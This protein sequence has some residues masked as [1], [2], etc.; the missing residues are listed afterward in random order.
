MTNLPLNYSRVRLPRYVSSLLSIIPLGF[1]LHP[2]NAFRSPGI[3]T[4]PPFYKPQ[5]LAVSPQTF[6]PFHHRVPTKHL[7]VAPNDNF[8]NQ[9]QKPLQIPSHLVPEGEAFGIFHMLDA[10]YVQDRASLLLLSVI[11][12]EP[13]TD[14]LEG[15]CST[16]ELYNKSPRRA[17][18]IAPMAFDRRN[19]IRLMSFTLRVTRL[20]EG[21]QC[22]KAQPPHSTDYGR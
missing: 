14:R 20:F 16:A 10:C 6:R 7:R 2:P 21:M 4:M 8:P 18:T 15:D 22:P 5:A 11:G 17:G 13:T 1:S 12:F 3:Q 9:N 19:T